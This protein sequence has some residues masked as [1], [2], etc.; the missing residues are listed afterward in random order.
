MRARTLNLLAGSSLL[1]VASVTTAQT[2]SA[3]GAAAADDQGFGLEEII[4][5]AR[6]RSESLQDVPQTVDAVTADDIAKLNFQ[7][8]TDVT[9]LVPGLTMTSGS[10]GYTTAATIRGASFQVESGASPT[11]EFYLND[12]PIQSVFLFQSMFDV[13]QIEVLRGPQGT[14]RG[15]AAPSGSI[16]VTTREPDVSEF[17]GYVSAQGSDENSMQGQA[18]VNIPLIADKLA[19]RVAGL[20]DDNDYD[21][22]KSIRVNDDPFQR[23]KGGRASLRWEAS[24]AITASVMYQYLERDLHSFD[25]YQSFHLVEPTA[26]VVNTATNP[27]IR[28][29]DRLSILDKARDSTQKF[30]IATAQL[31]WRLGGQKL[32]YVGTYTKFE[33]F[34][35]GAPTD[36]GGV[37]TGTDI[38][39]S[40]QS[41]AH[42]KA[43]ELRLAS[44]ERVFGVFDY[45]VGAFYQDFTSPTDLTNKTLLAIPTPGVPYSLT[46][47]PPIPQIPQNV[48]DT[49]I[50]RR[51]GTE[52][53]SVFAGVT[54][55]LTDNTE[56]SAG[57]RYIEFKT[58]SSLV[59]NGATLS[60]IAATEKPTIW[61][62]AGSH[63]FSDDFMVYANIGTS[64]RDGPTVVGVFRPTTPNISR[65]T[66]LDS[67]DSTSYEL[68]F[69]ADFLENRLRVNLSAFHQDFKDFLYRGPSVW[70][71]NL[72]RTG[73]VPAQFNFVANVDA[74]VDGAELDVAFQ[75]TEKLN[76]GL[77]FAYAKGEMEDGTVACNDFNRDGAPDLKPPSA[78]SVAD[79]L[80]AVGTANP[81][82]EA[83][84]SCNVNDRLSFAPDWSS[85]LQAEYVQPL[86]AALDVFGRGLYTYYTD[87]EQDPNNAYDNVDAYG[88]LN[89]YAGIRSNDGAWEVSLFARNVLDTDEVL[90]S[91]AS[92][93][94]TPYTN[95]TNGVGTSLAGPY[96]TSPSTMFTPMRE[97]GLSVRYSFGSR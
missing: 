48:V 54:Y 64:W 34:P 73:A 51:S 13:G 71:V 15:R 82:A 95:F 72:G 45:T 89:L 20:Y 36:V 86:S 3:A 9:A 58:N 4:V 10:T 17:G 66:N 1:L 78:P 62:V 26:P 76:L 85:T 59:V 75:A 6:R 14:L 16:T 67:E 18:A 7:Q 97:F 2:E 56:F 65:F 77:T 32:S 41:S 50:A 23:T 94:A 8:F 46:L 79:I 42:S 70:Y 93:A 53:K 60:D 24:D 22:V 88:L 49:V 40:Q 87:N 38:Y 90:N 5:T 43:H 39:N 12:A 29:S 55:H 28:P 69:K 80:T 31:D 63:R 92:A 21:H 57:A 68:G 37:V 30:D 96:V 44:E 81:L 19:L 47:A 33:L 27:V 84:A 83:V 91:N 25:S 74:K 35:V 11:V 61:N 52:E